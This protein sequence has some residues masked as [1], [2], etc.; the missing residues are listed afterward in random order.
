MELMQMESTPWSGVTLAE[1][2]CGQVEI[3][4]MHT[5][6]E[7]AH[8]FIEEHSKKEVVLPEEFKRHA[9]LFSDKEAKVFPPS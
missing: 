1:M 3:N 5:A 8:E 4:H 2:P 6:V 7:M 9:L